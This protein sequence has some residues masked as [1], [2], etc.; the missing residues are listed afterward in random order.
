MAYE[1]IGLPFYTGPEVLTRTQVFEAV[2]Q[3]IANRIE[4]EEYRLRKADKPSQKAESA[5]RI[6]KLASAAV[7]VQQSIDTERK[8]DADVE[9]RVKGLVEAVV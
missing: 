9:E 8:V 2:L 7:L 4:V 6:A 3:K 5:T 1:T